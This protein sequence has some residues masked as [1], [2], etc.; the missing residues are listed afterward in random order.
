MDVSIGFLISNNVSDEIKDKYRKNGFTVTD[1]VYKRFST[2][3]YNSNNWTNNIVFWEDIQK[4]TQ[5]LF[6]KDIKKIIKEI[7]DIENTSN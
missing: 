7:I 3:N 5:S 6:Y 4:G 2:Y 1:W